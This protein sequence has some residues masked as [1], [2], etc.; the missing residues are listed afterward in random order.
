M[1]SD[2]RL[3]H[4]GIKHCQVLPRGNTEHGATGPDRQTYEKFAHLEVTPDTK[5]VANIDLADWHP[6][7]VRA[8]TGE[9]PVGE[10]ST[11]RRERAAQSGVI[12]VCCTGFPRLICNLSASSVVYT[13][14]NSNSRFTSWSSCDVEKIMIL[15][16]S[17]EYQ[18]SP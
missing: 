7:V 8:H 9:L 5:L 6:F 11:R 2:L 18:H 4:T 17:R 14:W 12:A 15:P 3:L 1:L 16:S 10:A 13:A